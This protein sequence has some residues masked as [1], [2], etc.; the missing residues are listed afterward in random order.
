MKQ[1]RSICKAELRQLFCSP[2]A[3]LILVLFSYQIYQAFTD[4]LSSFVSDMELYGSADNVTYGL[5]ANYR[6]IYKIIKDK[7]YLFIPLLT[8]GLM[9]RDLNSGSIK[10][11]YSSPVTSSQIII[12]KYLSMV[13]FSVVMLGVTVPAIIFTGCKVENADFGLIFS[14]LAGQFLLFWAYSAI[15][16]FMS[17]LTSYQIVAAILTLAML[18]FLD[19]LSNIG[20][21]LD[22]VREIT[23][24]ASLSGRTDQFTEG[25]VCS[26]D[27]IY[28]LIVILLFISFSIYLLQYKRDCRKWACVAKYIGTTVAA[29]VVGY[30]SSRPGMILYHDASQIEANTLTDASIKAV[31]DVPGR[32][33]IT[34]YVNLA[35]YD[36]WAGAPVTISDDKSRYKKYTRFKPDIRM[37]YVYYYDEAYHNPDYGMSE[38]GTKEMAMMFAK[39]FG[40]PWEKIL[41]PE[42]IRGRIDLSGEQNHLVK[43][44]KTEDGNTSWLRLFSDMTRYPEEQEITAALYRLEHKA[45][46]VAFLTGH[47]ERDAYRADDSDYNGFSSALDIRESL[48]NTGFDVKKVSADTVITADVLVLAD[49]KKELTDRE[50]ANILS[51]LDTG[52]NMILALE[53]QRLG[54]YGGLLSYLGVGALPGTMVY[55]KSDTAP[56]LIPALATDYASVVSDWFVPGMTVSMPT[57]VAIDYDLASEWDAVPVLAAP[58]TDCWNEV[59]VSDFGSVAD[60]SELTCNRKA[61][62]F[63]KSHSLAIA[64]SRNVGGKEQR[65]MVLGDADCLSNVEMTIQRK[66]L[67]SFNS[68]FCTGIFN[69][70]SYGDLPVDTSRKSP[71][72]NDIHITTSGAHTWTLLLKWALQ[73][74]LAAV[75][76]TI[77]VRRLKR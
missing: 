49:L 73:L 62:E 77:I 13:V 57:A 9:S 65:V 12:G 44:L 76:I 38:T 33:D 37:N 3:W 31:K 23:Y 18:G 15:G 59:E 56:T 47:N 7:L 40:V 17:S 48:V 26:E 45:P 1:I 8:M 46:V 72:D 68:R 22:F 35:D 11:L 50:Q 10:L 67:R 24:W 36:S 70:M 27:I 69:W 53:P 55:P 61:G 30:V 63:K 74:V 41:T 21:E 19:R 29:L 75:G 34:T 52:G 66:T 28:F 25:L 71:I 51:F 16:L 14:G 4:S 58:G 54:Q 43:Q 20:Q 64:L 39:G 32:L 5:F 60:L 6:G 2:I 42:Q